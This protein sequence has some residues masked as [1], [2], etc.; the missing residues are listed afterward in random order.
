MERGVLAGLVALGRH[1]HAGPTGLGAFDQVDL[2]LLPGPEDAE[3]GV[4]GALA[5]PHPA[6]AG[7]GAAG[8]RPHTEPPAPATAC[9][10]GFAERLQAA[11]PG[12]HTNWDSEA[13]ERRE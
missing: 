2:G 1:H 11:P 4:P 9:A 7:L 6:G 12:R 3:L 13:A 10:L 5:G 8:Q